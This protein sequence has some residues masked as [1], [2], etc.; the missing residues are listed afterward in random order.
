MNTP[1]LT[2]APPDASRPARLAAGG[3]L[4]AVAA[5]LASF[6]V[7]PADDGGTSAADVVARYTADGYLPALLVQSAGVVGL[8]VFAAGLAVVL[9]RA[10]G[11]WT[12]VPVLVVAGAAVSAALQL[13]GYAVITTLVAGAAARGGDDVVLALYDLSSIAFAFASAGSAVLLSAAAVGL[14]KSRVTAGWSGWT[15]AV[16]AAVSVVAAGSL[17]NGGFFG[18]H[19]DFGFVAIVLVHLWLLSVS[20]ALLRRALPGRQMCSSTARDS[21][22]DSRLG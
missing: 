22:P 13:T 9:A 11:G 15:A 4:A 2:A 16:L 3:G 17:A 5:L 7:L 21:T 10:A 20:V 8:I 18:V 19:G 6:A 1:P 12:P 14:L